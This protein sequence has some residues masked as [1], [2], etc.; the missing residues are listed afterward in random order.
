MLQKAKP[1]RSE[2]E[3]EDEEEVW[4]RK[5]NTMILNWLGRLR[6]SG[7]KSLRWLYVLPSIDWSD[8]FNWCL[9]CYEFDCFGEF[10]LSCHLATLAM[11]WSHW[12]EM[13]YC[14]VKSL[15]VMDSINEF[16]CCAMFGSL[17]QIEGVLLQKN[18]QFVVF[19]IDSI[20][21][22]GMEIVRFF[23]IKYYNRKCFKSILVMKHFYVINEW[24]D[25]I[26]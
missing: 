7:R 12:I 20:N 16:H 21:W 18:C 11:H 1:P 3:E 13:E 5:Y 15:T 24:S 2:E 10:S 22:L 26:W 9:M 8:E 23:V 17:D 25:W 4:N 19:S 14:R 6:C